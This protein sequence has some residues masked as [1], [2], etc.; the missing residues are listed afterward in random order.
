[1]TPARERKLRSELSGDHPYYEATCDDVGRVFI[2]VAHQLF[3]LAYEPEEAEKLEGIEGHGKRHGEW[4]KRQ[5]QAALDRL[6]FAY[7][8]IPTVKQ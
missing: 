5:A 6:A 4:L 3:R 1:M 7:E 2:R 8:D